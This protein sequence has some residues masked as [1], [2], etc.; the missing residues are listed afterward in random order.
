[1]I[2]LT[3]LPIEYHEQDSR[4]Q[5]YRATAAQ[6]AAC[7]ETLHFHFE[8]D[9]K[10][11]LLQ[12]GEGTIA[13]C[14]RTYSPEKIQREQSEWLA[15]ISEYWFWDDGA[16]ILSKAQVQASICLADTFNGDEIIYHDS[17]YYILPRD[18]ETIYPVGDTFTTVADWFMTSGVIYEP[19]PAN[20]WTFTPFTSSR[21][22]NDA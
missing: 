1:M 11:L 2:N 12:Y 7:E 9:Y 15:R 17:H 13:Y 16:D 19:I 22:E 10:N 18:S 14:I 4:K 6:I 5:L 20:E 3:T 8:N 21:D